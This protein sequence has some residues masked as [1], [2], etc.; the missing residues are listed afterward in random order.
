MPLSLRWAADD[1]LDR[2][3]LTRLR[4]YAG[5]QNLL[6]TKYQPGIRAD[7]R[8]VAGDFLLAERDGRPVGT[9]ASMRMTMWCRGA[10][11]P[12]QGVAYVGTVK[13]ARR[14]G[15]GGERG[16]ASAVMD[17]MLK[18]ARDRGEIVTALMPFRASYYEHFGYGLV[19][20]RNEWT[21]PLATLPHGDFSGF[22]FAEP[23]DLP[24]IKALRQRTCE[25]GQC[26]IETS[27]A[28]WD[29]ALRAA[30]GG[31][32]FIDRPDPDGPARAYLFATE[33]GTQADSTLVVERLAFD[34][35]ADLLRTLHFLASLRDQHAAVDLTLPADLPL[36]WLLR[37]RQLPH[38]PVVHATATYRP[39]TRMQVRILDHAKYLSALRVPASASGAATVAVRESEGHVSRF[40]ATFGG[41]RIE[42]SAAAASVRVE[43]SDVVWAAVATGD[44]TATA[45][46]R[47]GLLDATDAGAP[48]TLDA[49]A[50]G[51]TP[52][53]N[54]YF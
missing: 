53:C 17:E 27:D 20:R 26:D 34:A 42:V 33:R 9:A 11:L 23:D 21:L 37:E 48:H 12:C 32:T 45:A 51:P 15:A 28:G 14:R 22:R 4:C 1:E 43:C 41:G 31:L 24:A 52:F 44:L 13:T 18:T 25:A 40:T 29:Y 46:A 38:R 8:A 7:G 30:G 49:L 10:P 35:P 3:A 47:L 5:S 50:V 54:E 2:V 36:N 39:I 16:V 6:E 19:E